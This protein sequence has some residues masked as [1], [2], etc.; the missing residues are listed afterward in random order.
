MYR[1]AVAGLILAA[2]AVRIGFVLATPDYRL[3]HDARDY[4]NHAV[5]IAS[6]HGFALSYGRPTAFRPPAYPYFLAGVYKLGGFEQRAT[7]VEAARIAN[8]FVGTGIVALI[9]LIAFQ[10]WGRPMALIALGLGAV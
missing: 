8:A 10:I 9:G 4:H 2:L 1:A 6:G 3:V 7:R 5:S